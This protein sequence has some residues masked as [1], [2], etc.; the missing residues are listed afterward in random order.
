MIVDYLGCVI[1]GL[2]REVTFVIKVNRVFI[3][4]L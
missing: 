3:E 4:R 1:L 2:M